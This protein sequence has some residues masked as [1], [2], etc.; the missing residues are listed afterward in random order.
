MS[1]CHGMFLV[2]GRHELCRCCSHPRSRRK[3]ALCFPFAWRCLYM[4]CLFSPIGCA[5]GA[6][7]RPGRLLTLRDRNIDLPPVVRRAASQASSSEKTC[8][9]RAATWAPGLVTCLHPSSAFD[10]KPEQGTDLPAKLDRLSVHR[11]ERAQLQDQGPRWHVPRRRHRDEVGRQAQTP[12][13]ASSRPDR[14]APVNS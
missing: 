13:R 3:P 7:R 1:R 10:A 8:I 12:S 14:I 4:H 6:V 2:T 9:A 5:R 11:L